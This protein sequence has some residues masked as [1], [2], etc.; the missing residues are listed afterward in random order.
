MPT[1]YTSFEQ[2][3][4]A[5]P[6]KKKTMMQKLFSRRKKVLNVRKV[7]LK[8]LASKASAMSKKKTT[9]FPNWMSRRSVAPKPVGIPMTGLVNKTS[10]RP[11]PTVQ[12][13]AAR[14]RV[15]SARRKVNQLRSVTGANKRASL[16][17]SLK[18]NAF[19]KAIGVSF[20]Q[21]KKSSYR[22]SV[23]PTRAY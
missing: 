17:A 14:Q 10:P 3:R 5:H 19:L 13:N 2:F 1:R 12:S 15:E 11:G 22:K 21:M 8:N 4:R 23:K 18:N 6:K 7:P 9:I 16:A 20:A